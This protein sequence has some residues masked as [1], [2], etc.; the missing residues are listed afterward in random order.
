ML[1]FLHHGEDVAMD[2]LVTQRAEM[3][4]LQ[5]SHQFDVL[6]RVGSFLLIIKSLGWP[7]PKTNQDQEELA[8]F[9]ACAALAEKAGKVGSNDFPPIP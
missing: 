6:C 4:T 8:H 9:E 3:M 7:I 5:V 1:R 2:V